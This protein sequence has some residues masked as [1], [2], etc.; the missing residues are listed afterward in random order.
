MSDGT[1]ILDMSVVGV[2]MRIKKPGF[3][4]NLTNVFKE[5]SERLVNLIKA[6]IEETN[7]RGL[8]ES[9]HA[10]KSASA[11]IGAHLVAELAFELEKLG[12]SGTTEGAA[13]IV[14]NLIERLS[15]AKDELTRLA[16]EKDAAQA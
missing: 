7:G 14:P 11:S 5:D 8:E 4:S 16:A 10:L 9:S 2:L 6:S 15:A 1:D 12:E 3:F 13:S